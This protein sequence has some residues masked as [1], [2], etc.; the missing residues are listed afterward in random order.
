M[1]ARR[2]SL[3]PTPAGH[4]ARVLRLAGYGPTHVDAM[5][6]LTQEFENAEVEQPVHFNV[7]MYR[8]PGN[9]P[10]QRCVAHA[11]LLFFVAKGN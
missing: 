9:A 10:G 5:R 2:R 8:L 11:E 7:R 3:P 1:S 4:E 6:S